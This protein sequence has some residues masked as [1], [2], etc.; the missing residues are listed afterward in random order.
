MN[1][2]DLILLSLGYSIIPFPVLAVNIHSAVQSFT[3]DNIQNA[4]L[5]IGTSTMLNTSVKY[6]RTFDSES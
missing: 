3:M 4:I 5:F 1:A 2:D 6:F